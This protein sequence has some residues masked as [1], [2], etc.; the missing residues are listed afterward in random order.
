MFAKDDWNVSS[1]K[2]WLLKHKY[3]A[4]KYDTTRNYI[5]WIISDAEPGAGYA[6]KVLPN[7]V[8]LVLMY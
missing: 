4:K 5:R 3:V 2:S 1:S 7:G 6:V 8:H